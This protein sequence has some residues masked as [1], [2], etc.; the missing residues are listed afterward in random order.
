[1][2]DSHKESLVAIVISVS[3]VAIRETSRMWAIGKV[4]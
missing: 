3:P 4:A 1:M 2:P